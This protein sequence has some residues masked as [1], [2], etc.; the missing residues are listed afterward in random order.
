M[1]TFIHTHIHTC[2][3]S[4]SHFFAEESHLLDSLRVP[5]GTRATPQSKNILVHPTTCMTNELAVFSIDITLAHLHMTPQIYRPAYFLTELLHREFELLRMMGIAKEDST[6][7]PLSC[8]LDEK[9]PNS[10]KAF[11]VNCSCKNLATPC[12]FCRVAV[13]YIHE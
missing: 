3:Y 6:M 8:K 1:N 11:K 9:L 13:S 12:C 10:Q 7:L 5:L 2:V 4:D